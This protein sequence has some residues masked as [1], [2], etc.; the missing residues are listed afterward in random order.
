MIDDDDVPV[1]RLPNGERVVL[2]RSHDV[3]RF[4]TVGDAVRYDRLQIEVTA[5]K[6]HGVEECAVTLAA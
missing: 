2:V 6:G 3:E 5:V 4:W 1:L